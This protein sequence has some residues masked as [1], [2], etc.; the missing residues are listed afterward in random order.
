MYCLWKEGQI[1]RE[2]CNN[3]ARSCKEKIRRAK[4]QLEL[5]LVATLKITKKFL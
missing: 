4:A 1:T 2:D 3:V 5:D